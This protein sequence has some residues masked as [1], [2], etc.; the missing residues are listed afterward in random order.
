[1]SQR[2]LLVY[3]GRG[4]WALPETGRFDLRLSATTRRSASWVDLRF[5]PGGRLVLL[6][7]QLED[8]HWRRLQAAVGESLV[9][10]A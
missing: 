7:D 8:K 5:V 10:G 2:A 4:I 6:A 3:L 9:L 1:M